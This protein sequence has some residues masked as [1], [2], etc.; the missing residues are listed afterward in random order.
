M[1]TTNDLIA[2]HAMGLDVLAPLSSTVS[3]DT[4][5]FWNTSDPTAGSNAI[6]QDPLLTSDYHVYVGS[7]AVDVGPTIPWLAVDLEGNPR[8][9]GSEYEIGA[10][11]GT[12]PW[13]VYLPVGAGGGRWG[14]VVVHSFHV[15]QRIAGL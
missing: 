6:Q 3:G 7:P 9:Q 8:P 14:P 4:N 2:G 11:E 10:Y 15:E 13:E 1:T 12:V 5:L